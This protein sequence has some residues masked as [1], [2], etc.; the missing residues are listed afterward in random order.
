[1]V[2]TES[3]EDLIGQVHITN[4]LPVKGMGWAFL[5]ESGEPV[6]VVDS[7]FI[8]GNGN[9]KIVEITRRDESGQLF[10]EIV[11]LQ[12]LARKL[13]D[14]QGQ[15]GEMQ[16]GQ[17]VLPLLYEI[18]TY[19]Q[20]AQLRR[21]KTL[22]AD[23]TK[24]KELVASFKGL[25]GDIERKTEDHQLVLRLET[26]ETTIVNE[27]R[28]SARGAKENR[29]VE[30]TSRRDKS[31]YFIA[32]IVSLDT[33]ADMLEHLQS[34]VRQMQ[35]CQ[36][37]QPLLNQINAYLREAQLQRDKLVDPNPNEYDK[38]IAGFKSL[39]EELGRTSKPEARPVAAEPERP[40]DTLQEL[41]QRFTAFQTEVAQLKSNPDSERASEIA[42]RIETFVQ[43]VNAHKKALGNG[44]A[45]AYGRLENDARD[46]ARNARKA[47]EQ[48]QTTPKPK[49]E[50]EIQI[51]TRIRQE[52]TI[53]QFEMDRD[54]A[55]LLEANTIF[56]RGLMADRTP[57]NIEAMV[58]ERPHAFF[59]ASWTDENIGFIRFDRMREEDGMNLEQFR[60]DVGMKAPVTSM[61]NVDICPALGIHLSTEK[62]V[63]ILLREGVDRATEQELIRQQ[64]P[65]RQILF[66]LNTKHR[67]RITPMVEKAGFVPMIPGTKEVWV[68]HFS[69]KKEALFRTV[70]EELYAQG[71]ARRLQAKR[72]LVR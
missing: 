19:L 54:L 41:R 1:M 5:L 64:L 6:R 45:K 35:G 70:R 34:E 12:T 55:P 13:T 60:A 22:G 63:E 50:P 51:E 56:T 36:E 52:L 46:L 59:V 61:F 72:C 37:V 66:H 38:V 4:L 18:K 29:L 28:Y 30:I 10:A 47:G 57:V 42:E 15:A 65:D 14:L 24:C 2:E 67:K 21:E 33:I 16:E 11:S 62:A 44:D 17:D 43:E 48:K 40:K 71:M 58:R 25:V 49:K 32:E 26:G 31:G 23:R 68:R 27:K 7:R 39:A 20:E 53:R 3:L 8:A 9:S 69:C